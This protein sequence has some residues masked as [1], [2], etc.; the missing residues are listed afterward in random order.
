MTISILTRKSSHKT[1]WMHADIFR[2]E[3]HR[4]PGCHCGTIGI[5]ITLTV[6]YLRSIVSCAQV[7]MVP[8]THFEDHGSHFDCSTFHRYKISCH[9]GVHREVAPLLPGHQWLKRVLHWLWGEGCYGWWFVVFNASWFLL[10]SAEL[11]YLRN[12]LMVVPLCLQVLTINLKLRGVA[13][14]FTAHVCAANGHEHVLRMNKSANGKAW[15]FTHAVFYIGAYAH[16]ITS[17]APKPIANV[18]M[19][20]LVADLVHCSSS[21]GADVSDDAL[22]RRDG[23]RVAGHH[24]QHVAENESSAR[25]VQHLSFTAEV[26]NKCLWSAASRHRFICKLDGEAEGRRSSSTQNP[27]KI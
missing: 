18:Q 26:S 20:G 13:S 21:I 15:G 5:I 9:G 2:W 1:A 3:I 25:F 17:K 8:Q 11:L 7:V 12:S 4:R 22:E 16:L 19:M 23:V 27:S 6:L 14:R 24:T 10:V